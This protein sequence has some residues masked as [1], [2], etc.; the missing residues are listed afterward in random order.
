MIVPQVNEMK[1]VGEALIGLES[2]DSRSLLSQE[3]G[4]IQT[5]IS[6]QG[7]IGDESIQDL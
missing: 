3:R 1:S 7:N 4:I 2:L 5:R 6:R